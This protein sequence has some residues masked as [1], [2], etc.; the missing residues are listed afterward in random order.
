[1][2]VVVKISVF[3][4]LVTLKDNLWVSIAHSTGIEIN[5]FVDRHQD[6]IIDMIV[7]GN[8]LQE[9]SFRLFLGPKSTLNDLR[10]QTCMNTHSRVCLFLVSLELS[11][12]G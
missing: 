8:T 5:S 12:K 1:M 7:S 4:H 2:F 6:S 9:V 11:E 3:C 10:L